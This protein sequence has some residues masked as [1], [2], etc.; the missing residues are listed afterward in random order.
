MSVELL[1][2]LTILNFGSLGPDYARLKNAG[3]SRY[4]WSRKK[5]FF[6]SDIFTQTAFLFGPHK[7]IQEK[8][9]VVGFTPNWDR[10]SFWLRRCRILSAYHPLMFSLV[11]SRHK[12]RNKSFLKP[13]LQVLIFYSKIMSLV[14]LQNS[15]GI[16]TWR[17]CYSFLSSFE[18]IALYW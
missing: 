2:Q 18:H 7:E 3:F 8:L 1:V 11:K 13:F 6:N 5:H 9:S 15:H 14:E 12:Y 10:G 16:C 4:I 17:I